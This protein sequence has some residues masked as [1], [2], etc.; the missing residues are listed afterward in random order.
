[1]IL[2]NDPVDE[3]TWLRLNFRELRLS[4]Q[5][6]AKSI[7]AGSLTPEQAKTWAKS[8]AKDCKAFEKPC[9]HEKADRWCYRCGRD[10][11]GVKP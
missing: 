5:H 8:L 11:F 6:I 7:A 4:L 2:L 9:P 10:L 3:V 1:M